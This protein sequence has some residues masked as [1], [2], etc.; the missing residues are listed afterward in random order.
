MKGQ[1]SGPQMYAVKLA[2]YGDPMS[3]RAS[4]SA[5]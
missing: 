2:V 4:A 1:D 5:R 3:R